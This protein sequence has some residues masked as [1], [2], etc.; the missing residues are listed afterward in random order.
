MNGEWR[1][2]LRTFVTIAV[3][4]G[5]QVA[6]LFIP[7]AS[8]NWP[9][10]WTLVA[11]T[12]VGSLISAAFLWVENKALLR[13]RMSSPVHAGQPLIDK[14][15]LVAFMAIFIGVLVISSVDVWHWQ[16][17]EIALT[18]PMPVFVCYAG[19]GLVLAG[20]VV[21]IATLRANAF[22]SQVVKLQ[23]ERDHHVIYT[24]PYGVVR[25]PMYTGILMTLVGQPLWLGSWAGFAVALIGVVV[26]GTRAVLEERFLS[27]S[28]PGYGAYCAKVRYRLLPGIW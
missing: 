13:E 27:G 6:A 26:M 8:W 1:L 14:V 16:T 21:W 18:P 2:A 28:L 11:I 10:A 15:L 22:A 3:R 24:G 17:H 9:A 4:S 25:H 20:P 7:A 12:I 23:S 19:L 5:L